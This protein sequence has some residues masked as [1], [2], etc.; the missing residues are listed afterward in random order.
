[1][2]SRHVQ[3]RRVTLRGLL[4]GRRDIRLAL[5]FSPATGRATASS[6]VDRAVDGPAGRHD[7][8]RPR[9]DD[10]CRR[11]RPRTH[12][13]SARNRWT[14]VPPLRDAWL[15][16]VAEPV[17][18]GR[19]RPGHSE[20]DGAG[21]PGRARAPA[22]TAVQKGARLRP[23]P[24]RSALLPF[25]SHAG[26][27]S[28]RG[29]RESGDRRRGSADSATSG[30]ASQRLEEHEVLSPSAAAAPGKAT[31]LAQHRSRAPR[32]SSQPWAL[33]R[34]G[35]ESQPSKRSRRRSRPG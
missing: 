35:R 2:E 12:P 19:G 17:C 30:G 13:V 6:E 11:E 34:G 14:A 25:S 20:A 18:S 29:H 31:T 33:A 8:R 10:R 24:L 21:G 22:L 3:P 9:R 4:A 5:S 7:R 16:H 1:M 26:R 23:R 32:A 27:A 15:R 28:L